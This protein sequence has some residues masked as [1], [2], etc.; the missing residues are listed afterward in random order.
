ML[1]FKALHLLA[2]CGASTTPTVSED[3]LP[4]RRTLPADF[5]PWKPSTT[6]TPAGMLT[7]PSTT[8]TTPCEQARVA[9]GRNLEPIAAIIWGSPRSVP[10]LAGEESVDLL[11]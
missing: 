3:H 6:T 10:H 7:A 2:G 1:D 4:S 11:R 9:A 8:C 5:T